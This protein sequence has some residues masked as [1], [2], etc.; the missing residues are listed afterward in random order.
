MLRECS[1]GERKRMLGRSICF[2]KSV[3]YTIPI[4]KPPPEVSGLNVPGPNYYNAMP[5]SRD[6]V[7]FYFLF[8]HFFY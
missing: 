6:T 1:N 7:L 2:C 5:P 8:F 4:S 3:L